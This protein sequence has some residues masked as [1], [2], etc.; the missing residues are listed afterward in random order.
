MQILFNYLGQTHCLDIDNNMTVAEIIQKAREELKIEIEFSLFSELQKLEDSAVLSSTSGFATVNAV[1]E[2]AGGKK[3]K[4]KIF[5][6]PK[7]KKHIHKNVKLRPLNYFS[8]A[9]DGSV[10][11]VKRLCEMKE[12]K[13]RG[14][15]MA[16]H[17]NRFYCGKCHTTMIKKEETPAPAKKK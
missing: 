10:Q 6:T 5:T 8:V 15:F 17:K 12:C 9:K 13:G 2:I 14:I 1:A 16:S 11:K 7:R 4:K 3:K